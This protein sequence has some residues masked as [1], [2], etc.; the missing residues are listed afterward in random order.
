MNDKQLYIALPVICPHPWKLH[1]RISK[2]SVNLMQ[3]SR[4]VK[5]QVRRTL[6]CLFESTTQCRNISTLVSLFLSTMWLFIVQA[7]TKKIRKNK[8]LIVHI[9][10][11]NEPSK[12]IRELVAIHVIF[13]WSKWPC[14][15]KSGSASA[16]LLGLRVWIPPRHG[17]F[18]VCI[19][20]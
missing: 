12:S 1:D 3:L 15:L 14:G 19:V 6:K 10:I 11:E 16:L 17:Y 20:W 13:N 7:L 8:L 5:M 18:L 2:H 4:V 9:V